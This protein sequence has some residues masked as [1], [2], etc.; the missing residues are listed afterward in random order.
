SSPGPTEGKSVTTANLAISMAMAG[1]QVLLIDADLRRPMVHEIFG[2][3]NNLGLTTLLTS[4]T[5]L[6]SESNGKYEQSAPLQLLNCMQFPPIPKLWVITSGFVPPNPS[7]L[8]G[9]AKF[10]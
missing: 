8:L 3:E 7:E 5:P 4:E 6:P 10:Q 9:A 1:L 2:L